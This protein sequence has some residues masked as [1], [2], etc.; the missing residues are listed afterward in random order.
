VGVEIRR[1]SSR[2]ADR[3]QGRATW[4]AFSFGEHYD[5]DRLRFGPMVC[6]DEH[7]LG[8]GRGFETHAHEELEIVSWVVSGALTHRDSLGSSATLRPGQ[9]GHLRAGSGVTHSEIA[10]APQTRLVQVWLVPDTEGLT[11]SYSVAEVPAG[12][13][14]V[15]AVRP[16]D[17]STMYVAEL[18][19]G[20]SVLLPAGA[21][22]HLFVAS[23]A[24]LRSS[25]AEPLGQGDAFL[26]E[27]EDDVEV[28]AAVPTQLLVWTLG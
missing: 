8:D 21:R 3:G 16:T 23:G 9:V 6:H 5:P 7:L 2:F 20:E 27:A 1:G 15:E 25:L 13:G 14:F 11:P 4:H 18:D 22:R 19:G 26:I 10:A 28:T 12:R 24:L 17:G